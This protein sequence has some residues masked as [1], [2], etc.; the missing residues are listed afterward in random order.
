MQRLCLICCAALALWPAAGALVVEDDFETLDVQRWTKTI[1]GEATI[2][3]VDGGLQGKCLR[4]TAN[5]GYGYCS[6]ALDAKALAGQ[7]I[8]MSGMVKLVDCRIGAQAFATPKFHF[9]YRTGGSNETQNA[10]ERWVG[11]FDWTPQKLTLEV[12]EDCTSLVMDIGN[13]NGYGTF[14]VDQFKLETGAGSVGKTLSL[15]PLCNLGRSDGAAG[16]G[17][18]SFLDLGPLDLYALPAGALTVAD[19]R[20]DLPPAGANMGRTAIILKGAKR[21][22]LPAA[23]EPLKVDRKLP[24]LALLHAAAWAD[25][26]GRRPVY[27][28]EFTYAD[29]QTATQDLV[30]GVD[31]GNF[32]APV[33]LDNWKLAWTGPCAAGQTVG[34]GLSWIANPRPDQV[35]A[36]LRFRSAGDAVPIVLAAAYGTGR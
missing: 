19:L 16:D 27:A 17:R 2:K 36:S 35:V 30:A 12:P 24:R 26:A 34:V 3:V 32:D 1:R 21:P 15:L 13:Q 33:A 28:V 11:S 6:M 25:P 8:T 10:A 5:G 20:F 9:G 22:D 31:L 4:I 18:G 29:G 14:Y 7:T 23:T